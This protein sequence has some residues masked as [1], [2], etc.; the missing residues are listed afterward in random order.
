MSYRERRG[1]A[2]R[3][4]V[5]TG[6]AQ[7]TGL[8][9]SRTGRQQV[10]PARPTITTPLLP[11]YQVSQQYT[12]K[13]TSLTFGQIERQVPQGPIAMPQQYQIPQQII[14]PVQGGY[15]QYR[16]PSRLGQVTSGQT[17]GQDVK[18]V[19]LG[20]W[21]VLKSSPKLLLSG[22]AQVGS[23]LTNIARQALA[24]P[25]SPLNLAYKLSP[26]SWAP[27]LAEKLTGKEIYNPY[28]ALYSYQGAVPQFLQKQIDKAEPAIQQT[29]QQAMGES[30]GFSKLTKQAIG[31]IPG[32]LPSIAS[33]GGTAGL[34]ALSVPAS[35]SAMREAENK[36]ASPEQ[37]FLYGALVG[38]VEAATEKFALDEAMKVVSNQSLNPLKDI[39]LSALSEFLGEAT[40][41]A[42]SPLIERATGVDKEAELATVKEMVD[43]GLTGAIMA[44]TIGGIGMGINS[45]KDVI[46][47]PTKENVQQLIDDVE[48]ATGQEIAPEVKTEIF[49]GL[50]LQQAQLEAKLQTQLEQPISAILEDLQATQPTT[51]KTV[52]TAPETTYRARR[53]QDTGVQQSAFTVAQPRIQNMQPQTQQADITKK[54]DIVKFLKDTLELP[55]RL[56]KFNQR[57][58]GIYKTQPQIIRVK[59]GKDLDT[60]FHEV[61]HYFDDILSISNNSDLRNELMAL[62]QKTSRD[63]YNNKQV[64]QE[65]VAEFFAD[66]LHNPQM[67]QQNS[68]VTYSYIENAIN[69]TEYREVV[70]FVQQAVSNYVQ[71]SPEQQVLS[72]INMT[73]G[74]K[75][76]FTVKELGNKAY[77]AMFNALQPIQRATDLVTGG[78]KKVTNIKDFI[79]EYATLSR[80]SKTPP[81]PMEIMQLAKTSGIGKSELA[82]EYGQ[83]DA[84]GNVIGKSLKEI[85]EPVQYQ[86]EDFIAYAVAKRANELNQRGIET[87]IDQ[88]AT[89]ATIEKLKND[90][91]MNKALNELYEYNDNLLGLLVEEGIMTKDSYEAIKELNKNYIPF[92]R[93]MEDAS[94]KP[95]AQTVAGTPVKTIKG[96]SRDINNPIQ[97][98]MQNTFAIYNII[99]KNNAN[100]AFFDTLSKY[101]GYG[102]VFDKVPTPMASTTF[103]LNELET[104]LKELGF[105]GDTNKVVSIFKPTE[106]TG[107]ENVVKTFK[108][109]KP[110][111]YEIQDQDLYD[112]FTNANTIELGLLGK[113]AGA[114]A[115]LL[116]AGA[117]GINPDFAGRNVFRDTIMASIYSKY[118]FV[119]IVDTFKGLFEYMKKSDLYKQA[120]ADGA[121]NNAFASLDQN[122]LQKDIRKMLASDIKSK[123][124]N[125]ITNPL[126]ILRALNEFS[127]V[128][129]R[130]GQYRRARKKLGDTKVAQ[131]KAAIETRDLMDFNR[132]GYTAKAI[133]QLVPFFNAQLQGVD[134]MARSFKENPVGTTL[135]SISA[136]TIPSIILYALNHDDERYKRVNQYYKDMYWIVPIGDTVYRIPKPFEMGAI[137]GTSIERALDYVKTEDPKAFEGFAN[138]IKEAFV[139][140]FKPTLMQLPQELASNY[141]NFYGG[142]IVPASEERLDSPEQFGPSTSEVAKLLGEGIYS[143]LGLLPEELQPEELMEIA[144]SP[145]MLDYLGRGL[146]GGTYT[147]ITDILDKGLGILGLSATPTQPQKNLAEKLPVLRGL[148]VDPFSQSQYVND[149]YEEYFE[150]T[151]TKV[152]DMS[153][154]EEKRYKRMRE[155]YDYIK[156]IMKVR[157]ALLLSQ[158]NSGVKAKKLDEINKSLDNLAKYGLKQERNI[159]TDLVEEILDNGYVRKSYLK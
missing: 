56:K 100:N 115:R 74:K 6:Q 25:A 133:N 18:D 1:L 108:D 69:G 43:A 155:A 141:S 57:A 154:S 90:K 106:Y 88:T 151:E 28:E 143:G 41:E 45:A 10:T 85:L 42:S 112:A 8:T 122:Y 84:D 68:P 120:L 95:Q 70:D 148:T 61:G 15:A 13:P 26:Q 103:N 75:S 129:T 52:S 65:G 144:G 36:G 114:P 14:Q 125:V 98:I 111:Y 94:G 91:T 82:F 149:F 16:D 27:Q 73:P 64:M 71:Q 59:S 127:E 137:F 51:Q 39:A 158:V 142:P 109:G 80:G 38:G 53:A 66:Y 97:N 96:S 77:D 21:D 156:D 33:G 87:G 130:L 3:P 78:Q 113:I 55:I 63:S 19:G 153:Y 5:S 12:F 138:R 134:K 101:K 11:Q 118:G 54:S 119:P 4:D 93:V 159:D 23:G 9:G 20:A 83:V 17:L 60:I 152:S 7:Q 48:Q 140:N 121:L 131:Q 47:N 107:R 139:P 34:L 104:T 30:E 147:N 72:N 126:D 46:N 89:K 102:K 86:M 44:V 117:T 124:K 22:A 40:A 132:A 31:A 81:T 79:K 62:G 92:Y 146:L 50:D 49:N 150:L 24:N 128:G 135:K 157:E 116:R 99:D 29:Q 67:A 58:Y 136:I 76:Q 35:G 105:E 32:M 123:A 37:A 2:Q 110:Q 145:R